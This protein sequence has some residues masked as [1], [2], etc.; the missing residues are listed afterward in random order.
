MTEQCTSEGCSGPVY[1]R[2]FGL[3]SAC[4]NRARYHGEIEVKAQATTPLSARLW[5]NIKVGRASQCWPWHSASTT[6]G[7]GV[8]YNNISRKKVLAHRAAWIV[9]NGPIPDGEGAHGTVVMHTCDNRLCCNPAHLRLGTQA[10]NIHDMEA[11]GRRK[12]GVRSGERHHGTV[13]TAADVRKIRAVGDPKLDQQLADKF[14]MAASSIK[15]VR[16]RRTWKHII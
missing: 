1:V 5:Q 15:Q 11:K 12:H 13:L 6:R 10:D 2:K 7:Y 8:I 16:L 9:T 3:C 14:G 4:Y